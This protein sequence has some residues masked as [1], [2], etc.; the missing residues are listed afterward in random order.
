MTMSKELKSE[1]L[2]KVQVRYRR[3]NRQGK[4]LLLNDVC[5]DYKYDRKYAIKLLTG[6]LPSPSGRRHPGP[7]PRYEMIEPVV[8]QIWLTAEKPCG[9]RLV[10][11][12]EQWLRFYE[13]QYGRLTGAQRR[14]L[15]Q[16]SAAT[17]DR[18]LA[19]ARRE[20]SGRGRCGT[21]PGSLLRTEI[22]IRTGTWDLN[23]PGYLEADSVAHCG[24]TLMGNFIW[25]LTYTDILSGWTEGGAV[26]NKGARGVLA[27]TRE[28]EERLPFELLGF[29]SDN[30]GE[31]LNHHLYSYMRERKVAVE[32]TRS[33]PYHSDDNAHVEQKNWTWARKLLGYGRLEDPELVASIS[34]LYREVWAPWQNFFLPCLKLLEKWREGSHWRKRYELPRTA[35][36]RLCDTGVLSRRERSQLK[37][38]YASLNPFVL[39]EE[40]DRRLGKILRPETKMKNRRAGIIASPSGG[41]ASQSVATLLTAPLHRPKGT[42]PGQ[43]DR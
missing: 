42:S 27:A 30:G 36:A 13:Q 2:P 28:V 17:L 4:S 23:Q 19:E 6:R 15:K 24:G 32:F 33:R 34:A 31:F 16:V 40:L 5:D 10:P 35:Y 25:S 12:L 14:L 37:E 38:R 41:S 8:R 1:W 43:L 18:L 29:D 22:P 9:K 20:H 26:W 3:R 7:E 21:K 39:K 11:I